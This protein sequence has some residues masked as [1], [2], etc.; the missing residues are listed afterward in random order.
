MGKV[1]LD[2]V[3][4]DDKGNVKDA[5]TFVKGYQDTYGDCFSTKGEEG[6]PKTDPPAGGSTDYDSMSDAEYYKAT[7]E[8]KKAAKT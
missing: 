1:D 7:Y 2:K 8:A 6:T 5:D 4:L 3:E